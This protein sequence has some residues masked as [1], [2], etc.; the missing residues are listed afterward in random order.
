MESSEVY[1]SKKAQCLRAT[2][3]QLKN[4]KSARVTNQGTAL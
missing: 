4:A 1:S 3:M 2:G